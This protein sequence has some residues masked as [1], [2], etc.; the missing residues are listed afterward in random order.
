M[1]DDLRPLIEGSLEPELYEALE[2][3]QAD[4]PS[5]E[6]LRSAALAL[7]LPAAAAGTLT[8]AKAASAVKAGGVGAK[9]GISLL[10]AK[11]FGTGMITG[12]VT[13]TAASYVAGAGAGSEPAPAAAAAAS[14]ATG[15]TASPGPRAP[16]AIVSAPQAQPQPA[17]SGGSR[18]TQQLPGIEESD[19]VDSQEPSVASFETRAQKLRAETAVLDEAR[20]ALKQGQASAALAV[21]ARYDRKFPK[22]ILAPEAQVVRVRALL[23]AGRGKEA[24]AL[25]NR[26]L[27]DRPNDVHA[28]RLRRLMGMPTPPPPRRAGRTASP[29]PSPAPRPSA[30]GSPPTASF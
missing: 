8:A 2:S 4:G 5:P 3:A 11:W 21:L 17:T 22:P 27:A 7:G 9:S 10:L 28:L 1:S 12:L 13:A 30:Q 15:A 29:A 18:A 6:Q 14:V 23:K 20:R 25:V 16:A 26:V 19:A 24:Q